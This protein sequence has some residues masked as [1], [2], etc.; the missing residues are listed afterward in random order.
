M[1]VITPLDKQENVRFYT[2]KCG[3]QIVG[4]ER[5]GNVYYDLSNISADSLTRSVIHSCFICRISFSGA[6]S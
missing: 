1:T 4:T 6:S 3:F 2:D 5:D